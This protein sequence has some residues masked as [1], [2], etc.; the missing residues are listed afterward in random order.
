MA[1]L[2][3]LP[4]IELDSL[5]QVIENPTSNLTAT[6]LLAAAATILLLL[7]VLTLWGALMLNE[8]DDGT[9][10]GDSTRVRRPVARERRQR[11]LSPRSRVA[12]AL[13]TGLVL[14]AAVIWLGAATGSNSHCAGCHEDAE[15]GALADAGHDRCIMCHEDRGFLG[16][17]PAV[18]SRL[19]ME[20]SRLFPTVESYGGLDASVPNR[21]CT[22]CHDLDVLDES[23]ES[24][25]AGSVRMSHSEPL[26]AGARCEECHG[27]AGAHT[28]ALEQFR[29]P[30]MRNCIDCHD[31]VQT[32]AECSVCHLGDKAAP[33]RFDE[34]PIEKVRLEEPTDCSGCHST[35]SCDECHGISLPHSPEFVSGGHRTEAAFTLRQ[36]NCAKCHS[37]SWCAD[38]CHSGADRNDI[39]KI[40]GHG[41]DWPRTHSTA[42]P[43]TCSRCHSDQQDCA[44]C[45]S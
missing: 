17:L 7:L 39:S 15:S 1:I 40:W 18:S 6:A 38:T 42:D 23:R 35:E 32:S 37:V 10:E 29:Q 16:L 25:A 33:D 27:S 20:S 36:A 21:R 43:S 3:V 30:K 14:V 13:L 5:R 44:S 19:R 45:H 24:T 9:K 22:S 11:S 12:V 41:P 8:Q 31:G 34:I 2:E 26:E 4:D 28:T